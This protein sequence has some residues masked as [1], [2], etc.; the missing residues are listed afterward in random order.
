[1]LQRLISPSALPARPATPK[2]HRPCFLYGRGKRHRDGD[3]RAPRRVHGREG[4][5][6]RQQRLRPGRRLAPQTAAL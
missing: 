5:V 4:P 6:D 1:M 2:L 3:R